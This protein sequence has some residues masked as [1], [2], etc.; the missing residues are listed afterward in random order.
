M[1]AALAGVGEFS[2][3]CGG[4]PV[5][6]R[7]G[8]AKVLAMKYDHEKATY[9]VEYEAN[10]TRRHSLVSSNDMLHTPA[11]ESIIDLSKPSSNRLSSAR[12]VEVQA[13]R[14]ECEIRCD[15]DT[16]SPAVELFVAPP[17][18]GVSCLKRHRFSSGGGGLWITIEHDAMFVGEDRLLVSV[19]K[20]TPSGSSKDKTIVIVNGLRVKVD[21]ED[22]P[23]TE[24]KA[25][26]KQKRV[27]PPRIPLDQPPVLAVIKRRRTEWEE[28]ALQDQKSSSNSPPKDGSTPR[29]SS[30]LTKFFS[31][32]VDTTVATGAAAAAA[33]TPATSVASTSSETQSHPLEGSLIALEYLRQYHSGA[34][35]SGWTLASDKGGIAVQ[36]KIESQFS[37]AI[38]LHRAEK[39]VEGVSAGDVAAAIINM[40]SQQAW[41]DRLISHTIVEGY[42]NSA[43]SAF[44]VRTS[45]FP[46]RNRGF[47]VSTVVARLVKSSS[48]SNAP[49]SPTILIASRSFSPTLLPHLSISKADPL[50]LPEG[51]LIMSGWIIEAVDPYQAD[52]NYSIPSTR[53]IHFVAIDY[54]GSVPIAFNSSM[55]ALLPRTELLALETW[56]RNSKGLSA[57]PLLRVPGPMLAM[58]A[59]AQASPG[60]SGL[61]KED[62]EEHA[63][64]MRWALQK[65]DHGRSLLLSERNPAHSSFNFRVR[66]SP[67]FINLEQAR[68]E[69]RATVSRLR[70]KSRRMSSIA[71]GLD[72]GA[73]WRSSS[74]T[75]TPTTTTTGTMPGYL[76]SP[77]P[78]SL[79][80][81]R[82]SGS[83]TPVRPP[84]S[85]HQ[86]YPSFSNGSASGTPF[87]TPQHERARTFSSLS[88]DESAIES[89][90][91]EPVVAEIVLNP[92]LFPFGYSV[93]AFNITVSEKIHDLSKPLDGMEIPVSGTVYTI[94]ASP[95]RSRSEDQPSPRHLLVLTLPI[96]QYFGPPILDLLSGEDVPPPPKPNWLL[97]FE[98]AGVDIEIRISPAVK[99]GNGQAKYTFGD[100]E[101]IV[102][103]ERKSLSAVGREY[104]DEEGTHHLPLIVR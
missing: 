68:D 4:P 2:I 1:V 99:P 80:G 82:T 58:E 89:P 85:N 92:A 95:L 21:V 55:N 66:L 32:A 31:A 8:G 15:V 40:D 70:S 28:E 24:V 72:I 36:K 37:S 9:K 90:P 13:P 81:R 93:D 63:S 17:P 57:G 46:F 73:G 41:D 38:A 26:A 74:S 52:L 25:L 53:C 42:G 91:E 19:R 62:A 61:P 96:S 7:F 56:L 86:R 51:H 27:K 3:K 69:S 14:I 10:E 33:F 75:S 83:V 103:N 54:R 22:I 102:L 104:L 30:P 29:Y 12:Q 23:E 94:P 78:G 6:T 100:N 44:V 76:E 34:S 50:T 11:E 64:E 49:Y 20:G 47:W 101:L 39:V 65:K 48:D 88:N 79:R 5:A 67:D 84:L 87:K 77:L 45:G 71:S 59:A 18:Q 43:S 97:A 98:K 60:E 16:W 35:A